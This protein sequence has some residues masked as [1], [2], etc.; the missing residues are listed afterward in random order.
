MKKIIQ[1]WQQFY[2]Q[3]FQLEVDLTDVRIPSKPIEGVWRLLLI[4]QGLTFDH[5]TL[6]DRRWYWRHNDDLENSIKKNARTAKTSYALWVSDDDTPS[7]QYFEKSVKE[8]DPTL[9]IGQTL[10]EQMI[11]QLHRY[12]E[13]HKE[14]L[15]GT[16][17]SGSSNGKWVP[18]VQWLG[19]S[20]WILWKDINTP[21]RNCG[22][23]EVKL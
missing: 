17:C 14:D 4:P 18:C 16:L 9:Q 10:L 2:K 8:V 22:I 15:V 20:V 1:D 3:Y 5:P 23:R 13:G 21:H 11:H 6:R 7:A 19:P 12:P